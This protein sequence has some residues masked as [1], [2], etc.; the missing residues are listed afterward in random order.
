[1]KKFVALFFASIF[2][3]QSFAAVNVELPARK[4]SEVYLPVGNTGKTVSLQALT[5]MS[6]KEYQS[7]TGQ[8][9]KFA[10]KVAFKLTQKE[11]RKTINADGTVNAKKMERLTK[12]MQKAAAAGDRKNLKIGLILMAV[13]LVFILL[14]IVSGIFTLLGILSFVAGLVFLIIYLA[15][16]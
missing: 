8:H 10:D 11:L 12:K 7:V 6:V 4:A 5:T 9:L 13:G 16:M 15:G 1:M 14:G 2:M 3:V